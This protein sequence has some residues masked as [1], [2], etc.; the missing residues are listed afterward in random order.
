MAKRG[1][2]SKGSA[3]RRD[4][5]GAWRLHEQSL[6]LPLDRFVLVPIE[7]G[8]CLA[9]LD[10]ALAGPLADP[11]VA[12]VDWAR[13]LSGRAGG[14]VP[15]LLA[16]LPAD[17]PS[18]SVSVFAPASA[19]PGDVRAEIL[20]ASPDRRALLVEEE[21]SPMVRRV[22][23]IEERRPLDP[24][25]HLTQ[26]GLDSLMAVEL[27]NRIRSGLGVTVTVAT[28]L[29]GASLEDFV[30]AAC[31]SLRPAGEWEELSICPP[32]TAGS[33]APPGR[34]FRSS[35]SRPSA[36][37]SS[38]IES[39]IPDRCQK[40]PSLR[41]S[42]REAPLGLERAGALRLRDLL[43][44][45]GGGPGSRLLRPA[46]RRAFASRAG[47][48]PERRRR[49]LGSGAPG[50][51]GCRAIHR[52]RGSA[53]DNDGMNAVGPTQVRGP[54]EDEILGTLTRLLVERFGAR[55]VVLFGSRARG[56]VR[57]DSDYDVFVEMET[58]ERPPERTA[59]ILAEIGLRP[60]S[61]DLVVYTP[62]EVARVRPIPGTLLSMIES[63]GRVLHDAA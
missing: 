36:A 17:L 57:P 22:P 25:R 62:E 21:L 59:R 43:R 9:A 15:P 44:S 56:D 7:P 18:A 29:Q 54:S 20:S 4:R 14:M 6:S 37:R 60:W 53:G 34:L 48:P 28:L 30:D 41:P 46:C 32:L 10:A 24:R 35:P 58:A 55:R 26:A 63:E 27:R 52:P 8:S 45:D 16:D 1:T 5:S 13:Y 12:R 19:R 39:P 33:E 3:R 49:D 42:H 50:A 61:L 40:D 31:G 51:P 2:S 23:G 38:K 47:L 11:V